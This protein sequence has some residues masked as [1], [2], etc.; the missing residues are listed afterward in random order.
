MPVVAAS[1]DRNADDRPD[2]DDDGTD[3]HQ[4]T[5]QVACAGRGRREARPTG[6]GGVRDPVA[7]ADRCPTSVFEP[8]S[9]G[10]RNDEAYFRAARSAHPAHRS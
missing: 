10:L 7:A 8:G 3:R 4:R 5:D 6:A 9:A 1:D 2:R